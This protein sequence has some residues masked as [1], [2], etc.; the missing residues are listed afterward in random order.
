[1]AQLPPTFKSESNKKAC[2]T[3]N[4]PVQLKKI[5]INQLGGL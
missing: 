5:V 3:N 1:L 2:N 4:I